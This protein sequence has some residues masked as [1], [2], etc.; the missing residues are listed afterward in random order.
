M[1]IKKILAFFLLFLYLP[2]VYADVDT[3][4]DGIIDSE[5]NC[6]DVYNPDQRDTNQDGYGNICDPDLD[7]D[8]D[9][10]SDDGDIVEAA[11][12]LTP[13]SPEW[14][15]DTDLNGDDIIDMSDVIIWSDMYGDP[16]GPSYGLNAD[17]DGWIDEKDNCP[18]VTLTKQILMVM[19]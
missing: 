11:Y 12:G 1:K 5:D 10:T 4:N 7:N 19:V 15:S 18:D 9:V 3:D 2:L 16:P 17:G 6:V 8:G 13:E 14:D